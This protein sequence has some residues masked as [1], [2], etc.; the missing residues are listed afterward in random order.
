MYY[1]LGPQSRRIKENAR[2]NREKVANEKF[3]LI[4]IDPKRTD[5]AKL[6]CTCQIRPGQTRFCLGDAECYYHEDRWDKEFV[7]N[8]TKGFPELKEHISNIPGMAA[9]ITGIPEQDIKIVAEFCLTNAACIL[10]GIN[11]LDQH[12]NGQNSRLLALLQI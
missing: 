9:G 4:V 11:T 6:V 3:E 1:P 2:S 5:L 8:Y 10:Q 12:R 7:E